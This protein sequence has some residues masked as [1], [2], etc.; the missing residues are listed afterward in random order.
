MGELGWHRLRTFHLLTDNRSA[1][2]LV[3]NGAF[4]SRSKHI[5]VRYN[6]LREWAKENR[7]RLDFV[8]SESMLADICT[9]YCT[10][11]VFTSLI[12]QVQTHS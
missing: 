9:K 1:L 3:A 6:A 2:S 5:A 8:P 12:R 10:R 4:S 11:D 7:F